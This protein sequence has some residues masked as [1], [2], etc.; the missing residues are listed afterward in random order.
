MENILLMAVPFCFETPLFFS[1]DIFPEKQF[2]ES[3]G[4]I[5]LS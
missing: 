3:F 4:K 5:L 2:G 1:L